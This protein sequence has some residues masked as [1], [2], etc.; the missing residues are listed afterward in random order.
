[1]VN[2]MGAPD[3]PTNA[4]FDLIEGLAALVSLPLMEGDLAHLASAMRHLSVAAQPLL[5]S[6]ESFHPDPTMFDPRR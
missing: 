6:G 2:R 5:S 4:K 1:M 3:E